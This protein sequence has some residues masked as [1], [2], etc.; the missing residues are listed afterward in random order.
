M[1]QRLYVGSI[2][3]QLSAVADVSRHQH[4][5]PAGGAA[6]PPGAGVRRGH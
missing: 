5:G 3:Q 6:R 2:V 1:Y 4:A